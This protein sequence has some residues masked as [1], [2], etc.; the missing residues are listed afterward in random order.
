MCIHKLFFHTFIYTTQADK[1]KANYE[2]ESSTWHRRLGTHSPLYPIAT[3]REQQQEQQQIR[4]AI[5]HI[6]SGSN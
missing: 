2:E 6:C 1:Q 3:Q 5:T 4:T